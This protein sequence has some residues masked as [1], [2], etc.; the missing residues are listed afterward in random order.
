MV[1][2]AAR[3]GATLRAV[4]VS[5]KFQG[6][7]SPTTPTGSLTRLMREPLGRV[8]DSP[9]IF[10]ASP[11]LKLEDIGG[12]GNVGDCLAHGHAHFQAHHLGSLSAFS[13]INWAV[14]NSTCSR[15]L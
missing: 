13:R 4:W 10:P 12:G 15:S 14:R 5:G 7:I 11:A 8:K 9:Y 1:H 6:V 3:A 2:P